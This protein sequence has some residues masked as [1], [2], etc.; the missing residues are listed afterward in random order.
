MKSETNP[1]NELTTKEQKF[2][3]SYGIEAD[4]KIAFH[5]RTATV[6][7]W[8]MVLT[9]GLY[10]VYW[11]YKNWQAVANASEHKISPFWRV[12][13]AVFYTWPLFKIMVLQAKSRG[14]TRNYSGGW[15]AL[16]Y[17][18]L[19]SIISSLYRPKAYN[20]GSVTVSLVG[21]VTSAVILGY[22]Q[23]AASFAVAHD[24]AGN[25]DEKTLAYAGMTRF[26]KG[27]V[28]ACVVVA[29]GLYLLLFFNA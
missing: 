27:L 22:A 15:L 17:L 9:S 14:F 18:F 21:V 1:S 24:E 12:V 5:V 26:E 6:L 8:M 19:P 10:A 4:T 3:Q 23:E 11:F 20:A 7:F 16:G 28:T 29:V 13:F 25:G 2:L